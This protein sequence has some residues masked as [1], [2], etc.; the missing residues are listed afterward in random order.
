MYNKFNIIFDF[1]RYEMWLV[2]FTLYSYCKQI[3]L[4]CVCV[5]TCVRAC[6]LLIVYIIMYC[7]PIMTFDFYIFDSVNKN[8]CSCS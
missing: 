4:V 3:H 2:F 6:V 1:I 5:F 7:I 8:Y